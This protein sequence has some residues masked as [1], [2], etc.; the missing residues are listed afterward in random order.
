ME[1]TIVPMTEEHL[2]QVEALER[3]IFSRGAWSRKQLEEICSAGCAAALAA[4]TPDGTVVGYASAQAVLDEGNINNVAVCPQSRRQGVGSA[5]LEAL[6][7]FAAER[8][9]SFLTL[10]VRASNMGARALYAR[11]GYQE[12]GR[13][14]NYYE[15]PRED[16]ILM[17][18]EFTT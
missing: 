12:V 4:V 1:Y 3:T 8:K 10:E 16:A 18:L 13:R 9:L 7:L 14:K 6:R 2:D 15:F 11:H 5:L 17:T